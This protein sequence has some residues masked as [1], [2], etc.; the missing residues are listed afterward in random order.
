[1]IDYFT[2][3]IGTTDTWT[4]IPAMLIEAGEMI[5]AILIHNALRFTTVYVRIPNKWWNT[6]AF[7]DTVFL[8]TNSIFSTWHQ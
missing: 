1:M 3:R 4:R 8:D 5:V 7:G 6:L 2:F